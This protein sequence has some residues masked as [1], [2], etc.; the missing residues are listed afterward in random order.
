MDRELVVRAQRGDHD[1]FE[2]LARGAA[3]RLESVARL[4]TGD[5]DRAKDA[6]QE[7][8]VRTW[9]DL[10]TLRDPDRFDAW[11][12]RV[13]VRACLDM[14]RRGRRLRLE[15]ELTDTHHA[16]GGDPASALA[17][18]DLLE[19]A[20]RTLDPEQRAVIAVHYFLG[21][22]LSDVAES[23]AIPVGTAK[24]RLARALATLRASVAADEEL[25]ASRL[26]KGRAT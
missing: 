13:L 14:V 24:S 26:A 21:L 9:R 23:L 25:P 18:R 7:A 1:A 11:L 10:P 8:L 15:V 17:D 6:V 12:R 2:H 20:F 3:P 16:T 19:R 5:P 22:P 4:V